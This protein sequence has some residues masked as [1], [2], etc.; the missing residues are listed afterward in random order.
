MQE[1]KLS[2]VR[3]ALV[4]IDD[5]KRRL[6]EEE[7]A[8]REPIAVIG[9]GCRLPGSVDGPDAFWELLAG[10]RDAIVE[11]P[12]DRWNADA[13]YDPDPNVVG[14]SSSRWGG[15]VDDIDRFDA[16]FFGISPREAAS[17]DPQQ[18]LLLEVTWEAIE[19]AAI[20]PGEVANT[21]TGV[22]VGI[23]NSD[24]SHMQQV[25]LDRIDAFSG[26][27]NHFNMAAGRLSYFLDCQG[28]SVAVDT[29]CSSSL[30]AAD[31]AIHAM[32]RGEC[33]LAL[34][35]GV[36]AIL[37][38]V[39]QVCASRMGYMAADG[40]CKAY[41]GRADG[42]VRGEGCVMLVLRRL[43]DA[44]ACGDRIYAV[45]TGTAVNQDGRTNGITA[46]NAPSQASVIRKAL[47]SAGVD[48]S[49]VGYVE[50]H[51]AGTALGDA[52]E[53][54]ALRET[55][56]EAGDMPCYVGSVK[57]NV[58]HLESAAGVAGLAKAILAIHHGEIPPTLHVETA[59]PPAPLDGSRLRLARGR[60]PWPDPERRVAGVSGFGWSGTN[61]H[62]IVESPRPEARRESE[63]PEPDARPQLL[64]L[65]AN[66]EAALAEATSRAS[67]SL[68]ERPTLALA[69]A[70]HTLQVG[71]GRFPYRTAAVVR[72][73]DDA[74][75]VLDGD[76]P[77]RW[78]TRACDD[79]DRPV[80]FMFPGVGDHYPSMGAGLYRT[81]PVFRDALDRS[82][83]V[84]G[85]DPGADVRRWLL[86][87][88][89]RPQGAALDFRAMVRGR[90][91]QG[92]SELDSTRLAQPAVFAVEYAMAELLRAHGLRPDA[93]IGHSIGE[94]VAA[95]VAG[96]FELEDA[97]AAVCERTRRIDALPGGAM[98]AV[99]LEEGELG[100]LLP[101]GVSVAA[102]N[103][104]E[105]CV[106]SG[107]ASGVE[108]LERA[109]DERGA[110]YRRLPT[111]HAFHSEALRPAVAPLRDMVAGMTLRPPRIPIVSNAEARFLTA[112]EARDPDYWAEHLVRTVRFSE[113]LADLER[114][115]HPIL[116]EAGPGQSLSGFARQLPRP[117]G[118]RRVVVPTLRHAYD[119][120]PDEEVFLTALGEL[121]I[122][123]ARLD[124]RAGRSHEGRK[125]VGL[126]TY[127]F[128]RQ[129]H[130]LEDE[131]P[132]PS[133]AASPDPEPSSDSA[134]RSQWL[135]CWRQAPLPRESA[136][137]ERARGRCALVVGD[138][139]R[140]PL[141]D[142]LLERLEGA[143]VHVVRATAGP[144]FESD[145]EDRYRLRLGERED[146]AALFDALDGAMRGP[147]LLIQTGALWPAGATPDLAAAKERCFHH[148]I[149]LAQ[150]LGDRRRTSPLAV[151][152][153]S[154]GLHDVLGSEVHDPERALLLGPCRV[155]PSEY[156]DVECANLDVADPVDVTPDGAYVERLAALCCTRLDARV[157]ALRA[158]YAWVQ[159]Y[160]RVELEPAGE[161]LLR[162]GGTFLVTGGLGGI[163]LAIAERWAAA[164]QG[165][166]VLLG[167]TGLP[168]PSEWDRL[169]A[170]DS[171]D[172][173]LRERILGVRRIEANG[174]T[175]HVMQVDVADARAVREAIRETVR[176]FGGLDGVVHAAGVPGA[177]LI[178]LK[179]REVADAVLRPKLEG[180][181]ALLDALSRE[182]RVVDFLVLFSSEAALFGPVGQVDYAAANAYLGALASQAPPV[183]RRV[184]TLDWSVWQH[185][186]WQDRMLEAFPELAARSREIRERIGISFD[187][188][189]EAI[190]RALASGFSR[191]AVSTQPPGTATR[192]Y[193]ALADAGA[194]AGATAR[195]A[196]R[197]PRP[198][199]STAFVAP[200]D[201]V[202]AAIA[203]IWQ[204][205][206]GFE[207][208]GVHDDF[209]QLGGH[210][211]L[212]TQVVARVRDRFAFDL[213][214]RRIF[215]APTIAGLSESVSERTERAARPAAITIAPRI[216]ERERERIRLRV[217]AMSEAELDREL[218]LIRS[219]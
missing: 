201:E 24:Y 158:G 137:T 176:R 78:R 65:S 46:P 91:A 103:A 100:A 140:V 212:A 122:E 38:P 110:T 31:L 101:E 6:R 117:D 62:L 28:P 164:T 166:F 67:A 29:A 194:P 66:S 8:K 82:L 157:V 213:P 80:V 74:L 199:L 202:E 186:A 86:D 133:A 19:N 96:V 129:R 3:R 198:S 141:L 22:Y 209:L 37:T 149:A 189:V 132:A 127:P 57:S 138:A 215:E 53:L 208:I 210:S 182:E 121:W 40:R 178:Q 98:T 21:D 135:G 52:I 218:A 33:G 92:A 60:S 207:S 36:N 112:D 75:R 76:E 168:D 9:M 200:R 187:E 131:A 27:G 12:P 162:P 90:R 106:A 61:A 204:D 185:D 44:V 206:L 69:D 146:Y 108:A 13:F 219:A 45:I 63:A 195:P 180:T 150:A 116:I 4:A 49:K 26:T 84:M 99:G 107:P 126:P 102:V 23:C 104:P 79:Q 25:A 113:G 68:R 58:G 59:N 173:A 72:D 70:A 128:E 7:A 89:D 172:A 143:G 15:F 51:G 114:Q 43:S 94:W 167:R 83:G 111:T 145:G 10:G 95:C 17:L 165:T 11:V 169:L 2:A 88:V 56:G 123:G 152:I 5:L 115:L 42:F 20:A 109:L 87:P 191:L 161:D 197:H 203:D 181:R 154:N 190:A 177:G 193:M 142:A 71:R 134:A 97:V 120:R 196:A 144:A 32:R 205:L 105:L 118:D 41:D 39:G 16:A 188:G 1:Q 179:D 14:K 175:A 148:L 153:L 163:G 47:A 50:G 93:L 35:G 156:E 217:E 170:G 130:W 183:A 77:Q 214:V 119:G 73:R 34:V 139:E 125:T 211:L 184:V 151:R 174:G 160:E 55:V 48:A 124:W 155:I 30:V 192:T 81:E 54:E 159:T 147:D 136:W 64:L 85:E 18:R 171:L 216:E